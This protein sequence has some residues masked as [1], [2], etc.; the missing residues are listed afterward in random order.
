MWLWGKL[1]VGSRIMTTE[2]HNK[3]CP[4]YDDGWCF[5]NDSGHNACPDTWN[6]EYFKK[7]VRNEIWLA[8]KDDNDISTD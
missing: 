2:E 6:C 5:S 7:V 4:Y 3:R 8:K 1:R